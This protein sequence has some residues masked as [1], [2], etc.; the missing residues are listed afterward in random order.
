MIISSAGR[1]DELLALVAVAHE[2]SFALAGKLI[3]RHPT[4]ISKRIASLEGRLGVRLIERTTRRVRLTD[5][6]RKLARQV[7]DAQQLLEDAEAEAM[8]G[9]SELRGMI[10]LSLPAAMGRTWL[11]PLLPEFLVRHPLIQLDVRFS[12]QFVDLLREEV[13]IAVRIG[14]LSDSAMIARKLGNHRRILA[15]SPDYLRKS[16]SPAHPDELSDHACL[17]FSGFSSYPE[18]RLTNGTERVSVVGKGQLISSDSAA[19]VHAALSGLGILGG[20]EWLFAREF[21]SGRLVRVLPDWAF[22]V[23]GGIYLVRPSRHHAPAHITTLCEW[24]TDRFANGPP[25]QSYLTPSG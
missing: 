14:I 15:A 24:M 10:R 3:Q 25:W 11:A 16:G 23:D 4:I 8:S 6:G 7:Q 19:L 5:A 1:T 2:G 20:G 22:D 17:Q 21:A 13:D 9:S 12:D 18:W